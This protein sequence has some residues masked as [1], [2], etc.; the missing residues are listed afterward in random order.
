M[1][2][3]VL[4]LTSCGSV[5]DE[6]ASE[7]DSEY[8]YD[9]D[10]DYDDYDYE[11]YENMVFLSDF[12][13]ACYGAA[14]EDGTALSSSGVHP[15]AIFDRDGAY[16]SFYNNSYILPEAWEAS[17]ETPEE[18][19][20]V[21][22]LTAVP[23]EMAEACEYDIEGQNYTLNNYAASYEVELYEA[24][25]GNLVDSTTLDIPAEECPMYWYFFDLV[26]NYYPV[27]DQPLTEWITPYVKN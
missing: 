26:E 15:V 27:Y 25:T 5:M 11:D 20:L 21:V 1:L 4:L 24:T 16:D 17:Y 12:D 3:L 14:V 22:C 7:L 23:G 8:D 19:E 18:T 13:D 9:Y 6:I 10:Y 2:P